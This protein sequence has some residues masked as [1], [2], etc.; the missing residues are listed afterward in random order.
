VVERRQL[1]VRERERVVR[2][3]AADEG[4]DPRPVGE[5]EA[6]RVDREPRAGIPVER[7]EDDVREPDRP[8]AP[9]DRRGALAFGNE[10][11]G[12]RLRAADDEAAAAARIVELGDAGRRGDA[13]A[14]DAGVN[15]VELV[16][17]AAEGDRRDRRRRRL[18]EGEEIG[19]VAGPA[20]IDGAPAHSGREEPPYVAH[21][22]GRRGGASHLELDA[23]QPHGGRLCQTR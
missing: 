12:L 19:R 21:E 3:V 4:H 5:L 11:E 1:R 14:D 18:G 16:A 15:R 22:L 17:R 23:A 20:E 10:A 13:G 7:V 6:E 2:A 8:V 9:V